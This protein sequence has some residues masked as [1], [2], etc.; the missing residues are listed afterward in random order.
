MGWKDFKSML[1]TT[2]GSCATSKKHFRLCLDAVSSIT[3]NSISYHLLHAITGNKG[4]VKAKLFT[5]CLPRSPGQVM[6]FGLLA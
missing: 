6:G 5:F 1:G 2:S 3:A 4:F